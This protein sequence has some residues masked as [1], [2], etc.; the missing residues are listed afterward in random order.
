MLCDLIHERK[1]FACCWLKADYSFLLSIGSATSKL[2]VTFKPPVGKLNTRLDILLARIFFAE[3]L[4]DEL[5]RLLFT[6]C[7]WDLKKDLGVSYVQPD[8]LVR[9]A[10]ALLDASS[11]FCS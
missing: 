3:L 8:L 4:L 2:A 11:R 1:L 5:K 10:L 9:A 7:T 6:K